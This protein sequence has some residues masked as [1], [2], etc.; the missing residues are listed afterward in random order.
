MT[1]I[2]FRLVLGFVILLAVDLAVYGVLFHT[3]VERWLVPD[4][5]AMARDKAVRMSR[6]VRS[7]PVAYDEQLHA[8][9]RNEAQGYSWAVLDPEGR[10]VQQSRFLPAAFPVPEAARGRADA[11]FE[12]YAELR[13]DGN[14]AAHAVAWFALFDDPLAPDPRLSGWAQAVVPLQPL[15][16]RQARLGR[17]LLA[18]GIVALVAFS[19]LALYLSG[20]WLRPWQSTAEAARRL[21]RGDL[22][23]G[24]LPTVTDDPDLAR[25]VES[26]NAL[27]DRLREARGRQEQFVADAAHELRTPLAALRAEIEVA[28]RR[29][30]S[31]DEYETTLQFNRLELDRLGALV[32]NLLTLAQ[33]DSPGNSGTRRPLDLAALCREVAEQ[34]A[35]LA[36]ARELRLTLELPDEFILVADGA[37]IE[38]ALRNLLDNAFKHTP[39]GERIIL[40]LVAAGDEA[41]LSVEDHGLGI[42]PEHLPRLFDRF[43]RVDSARNRAL[44]GAGLGLAIVKAAAEAHG[45]RVEVASELGRGSRFTLRLPRIEG[46][47]ELG[48]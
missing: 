36:G 4:A 27:L 13:S 38:R 28:L 24:R 25:V 41:R 45:G 5:L 22:R 30:R 35:P 14:G 3:V 42:A 1:S 15:L 31:D 19:G 47:V 20:L 7:N 39:A 46:A 40:R 11:A 17:W 2:R 6:W 26:F 8:N 9:V 29:R 32:E 44:G 16:D 37:A 23:E 43:Y 10:P 18:A 12:P 21:A 48:T 33:L 34:M